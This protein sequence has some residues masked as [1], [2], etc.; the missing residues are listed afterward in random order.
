[1]HLIEH[2]PAPCLCCGRGNVQDARDPIKFV[3]LE[4][5]VNWNDPAIMCEDCIANAG[6]LVGMASKDVLNDF[7]RQIKKLE[8]ELHER[9]SKIDSMSRRAK[10]LGMT[11]AEAS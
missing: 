1:M 11:F 2:T 7:R 8:D 10:R 4:R 3:D 9:D 5:D 6:G